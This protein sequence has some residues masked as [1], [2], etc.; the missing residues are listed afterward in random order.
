MWVIRISIVAAGALSTIMARTI[1]S[2][3]ALFVLCSDLV[4]V[5]LFPQLLCAVYVPF[6][7]VYGSIAGYV[8]SLFLR[9]GGGE[10]LIGIK[11]FVKY[12]YYDS[13]TETQL[14]PYRT[15]SMVVNLAMLILVSYFVKFLFERQILSDKYD[16][17]KGFYKEENANYKL[18][19]TIEKKE[20]EIVEDKQGRQ[21]GKTLDPEKMPLQDQQI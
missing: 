13:E 12:P 10:K 2:V 6:V 21:E 5:I 17:F 16:V 20:K 7:N 14:F 19:G 8:F 4:F 18:T 11:P 1:P 9:I 3:Y 15:L